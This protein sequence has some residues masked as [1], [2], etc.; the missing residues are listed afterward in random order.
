MPIHNVGLLVDLR[1]GNKSH[2]AFV[3]G[4]GSLALVRS[5]WDVP[6]PAPTAGNRGYFP[7]LWVIGWVLSM[8]ELNVSIFHRVKVSKIGTVSIDRRLHCIKGGIPDLILEPEG[9]KVLRKR[10]NPVLLEVYM[11]V[12][13]LNVK[14]HVLVKIEVLAVSLISEGLQSGHNGVPGRDNLLSAKEESVQGLV[15]LSPILGL[16]ELLHVTP[17]A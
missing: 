15:H 6:A 5:T 13:L 4:L 9:L 7:G 3:R 8:L 11:L 16:V 10:H 12:M 17:P 2:L 1:L 14:V